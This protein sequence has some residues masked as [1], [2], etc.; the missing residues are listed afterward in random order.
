VLNAPLP[1][2]FHLPGKISMSLR[3]ANW[4]RITLPFILS[5]ATA[6]HA[7][8]APGAAA[9][10]QADILQRQNQ[11]RIQRD[12]ESALPAE[13]APASA[14]IAVPATPV[15]AVFD[16]KACHAIDQV[17]ILNAPNLPASIQDGIAAAYNGRCLGAQQMEQ[18]LAEITK[19]Y[20]DRGYVTTRAYLPTQNLASGTMQVL[21]IEGRVERVVLDDGAL[22]SIH[23]PGVFPPAGALLNLRDFE[24][25]IDQVNR[26]A[27]NDARLELRPG[28]KPGDTEVLI[29]NTPS[30]PYHAWLSAD[31]HGTDSTGRNQLALAFTA[32]RLLG[33]N[34]LLLVTHRR[35]QPNDE[36][37]KA[38]AADSLSV[39][40][41]FGYATAS[42]STSRS[43]YVSSVTTPGG[44]SLRFHGTG[45]SDSMR[46]ERVLYRDR[47]SRWTLAGS[48]TSKD[49]NNYL[50]D[51]FLAVSSRKLT[52]LD[53]DAGVSAAVR[54]GV[55]TGSLGYARGIR[56]DGALRDPSDLPDAAPHAQFG[57]VRFGFSYLK[58]FRMHGLNAQLSTQFSAQLAQHVLYGSE[59]ILIGGTYSV[60]GFRDSTLSGDH[61]W[62]SRNELSVYPTLSLGT[63]TPPLRL[64]AAIDAGGV[65]DRHSGLP[66]GRLAGATLGVS[67]S[68]KGTTIDLFH[69]RPLSQPDSLRREPA[70]AWL[71][72]SHAI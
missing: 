35:S 72:I 1:I 43:H 40:I 71:Q 20:I 53:I 41:P 65:K 69:A 38:S 16:G 47:D 30:R 50:A 9:A 28:S 7:Q 68:W 54:G 23:A 45:R 46:I 62:I 59:Q 63:M 32:D 22:Q 60:R 55:L 67:F 17:A 39:V 24:Q 57:K 3:P 56:L 37:R 25:G 2:C 18:I 33:L 19:S 61:G 10:R 6:A 42:F 66:Q 26:L 29:R 5:L 27:S 36:S 34:E 21:V 49:T 11:E 52:V 13:R 58:P 44:A 15:G 12:I 70:Q 48:L 31:N 51:E 64:Y 14:E 4:H 8:T